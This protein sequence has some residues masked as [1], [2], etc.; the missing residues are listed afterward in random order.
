M[1]VELP[2]RTLFESPTVAE[3]AVRI[4]ARRYVASAQ[5]LSDGGPLEE[6]EI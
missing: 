4:D 6:E 2:L 1:D 5:R 3:L